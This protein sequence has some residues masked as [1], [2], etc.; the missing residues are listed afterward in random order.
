MASVYKFGGDTTVEKGQDLPKVI[1]AMEEVFM[2]RDGSNGA[3]GTLNMND[4]K[5]S[6]VIGPEDGTDVATK[7]YVDDKEIRLKESQ[8]KDYILVSG[9][10][11]KVVETRAKLSDVSRDVG[12]MLAGKANKITKSRGEGYFVVTG[13]DGELVESTVKQE[14]YHQV[15]TL[16]QDGID[17]L[18]RYDYDTVQGNDVGFFHPIRLIADRDLII[19]RITIGINWKSNATEDE[20]TLTKRINLRI[21]DNRPLLYTLQNLSN[22]IVFEANVNKNVAAGSR[23]YA[24]LLPGPFGSDSNCHG[25]WCKIWYKYK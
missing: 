7:K 18:E 8:G 3:S 13:V 25:V 20:K 2:K 16:L 23:Y 15:H 11:N 17:N 24:Y 21:D 5:I 10:G 19:T 14:K 4:N 12:N 9:E 1:K 22:N 6:K